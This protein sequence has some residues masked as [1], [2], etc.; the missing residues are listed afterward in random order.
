MTPNWYN[1][2]KYSNTYSTSFRQFVTKKEKKKKI[3]AYI[4]TIR[5][6]DFYE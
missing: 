2:S 1:D 3:F 6:T 4:F 5:R